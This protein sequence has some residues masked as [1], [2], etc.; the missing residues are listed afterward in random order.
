MPAARSGGRAANEWIL[1]HALGGGFKYGELPAGATGHRRLPTPDRPADQEPLTGAGGLAS[2]QRATAFASP[3]PAGIWPGPAKP[4]L[5]APRGH[6]ITARPLL[7]SIIPREASAGRHHRLPRGIECPILHSAEAV[8]GEAGFALLQE[9]SEEW[10]SRMAFEGV[11]GPTTVQRCSLC[12]SW[13]CRAPFVVLQSASLDITG[14]SS[15]DSPRTAICNPCGVLFWGIIEPCRTTHTSRVSL[16][17][18]ATPT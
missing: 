16:R 5:P 9:N 13:C 8:L 10:L 15:S 3:P 14:M 2:G 7:G 6:P 1:S 11:R 12:T 18:C 4:P 17:I